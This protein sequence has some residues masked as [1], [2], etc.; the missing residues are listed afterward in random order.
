MLISVWVYAYSIGVAS[1]R[2]VERLMGQ[3]PG[4]RWL[5]ANQIINYH[6][7]ADF[8]VGHKEALADLFAQFLVLLE[9]EGVLDSTILHDGTKVQAVAGRGSYH[10]RKT[11]EKRL[12]KAREVV[13][14]LDR[15]PE[16]DKE[17]ME[18]RRAAAQRRAARESVDRLK[19]GLERLK[20]LESETS[21]SKHADPRVS[22]SE[23][24]ARKMK[25]PDGGFALSYNVQV[26]TEE[27]SRIIVGM[28]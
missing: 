27:K 20:R 8:R 2:A 22:A 16:Q 24:E 3:D 4:L 28:G 7:L 12:R 15:R 9:V 11:L 10:R 17:G 23:P 25:Q 18:A 26:S 6:T 19:A 1:A 13:R 14:E 5:T 21:P